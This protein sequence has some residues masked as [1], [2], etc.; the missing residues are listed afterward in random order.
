M[1]DSALLYEP[2]LNGM[3]VPSE[4]A[5]ELKRANDDA[6]AFATSCSPEDWGTFVPGDEWPVCV[7]VHHVAEGYG[8]VTRWIDCAL[9]GDPIEDTQE[10]I[11]AENLR[12]ARA[13]SSI[14][15]KEVVELLRTNGAV[16]VTKI[17]GLRESD[18]SRT[19]AF[20]P[21]KGRPFSVEQFCQVAT[22]HVRS[23]IGRAQSA[24]GH[25]AQPAR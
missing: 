10:G 16:A 5:A 15:V 6:I 11:D 3:T 21:A 2:S 7:V 4:L 23:H 17:A 8:L 9:I 25:D 20:G 18:L 22:G 12:H 13:F 19:T 24:I 1:A 14:G